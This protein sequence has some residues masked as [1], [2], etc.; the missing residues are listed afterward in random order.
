MVTLRIY[1]V[2]FANEFGQLREKFR[3]RHIQPCLL[4]ELWKAGNYHVFYIG[5][6]CRWVFLHILPCFLFPFFFCGICFL[7]VVFFFNNAGMS[8]AFLSPFFFHSWRMAL[9]RKRHR[10]VVD[11]DTPAIRR[12]R[13]GRTASPEPAPA[14]EVI[15]PQQT[16][17]SA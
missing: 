13:L 2:V 11:E 5:G 1:A 12:L 8:H 9:A 14:P 4:L 6:F 15:S 7:V 3:Y 17:T 16:A 10:T